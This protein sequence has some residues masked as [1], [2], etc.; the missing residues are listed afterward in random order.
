METERLEMDAEMLDNDDLLDETPDDNAEKIDA[1]SQLSPAKAATK[2]V[3]QEDLLVVP[4]LTAPPQAQIAPAPAQGIARQTSLPPHTAKGYLKK[5]VQK[6]PD[7]KGAK[8]SK[9]SKK[10]NQLR[11]R[12]ARSPRKRT[13][14]G[15]F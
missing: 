4:R 15:L 6:S 12:S 13:T 7:L 5:S 8:A 1:I 3:M 2:T 10:L 9:A 11:G 14:Q